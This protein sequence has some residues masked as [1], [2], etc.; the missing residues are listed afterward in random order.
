[1]HVKQSYRTI[2]TTYYII[3][4]YSSL[5]PFCLDVIAE[6]FIQ[7]FNKP[8]FI[9]FE[10]REAGVEDKGCYQSFQLEKL[11]VKSY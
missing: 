3:S 8:C 2:W 7:H 9:T 5:N 11:H 10:F 4:Y 1:M 6:P